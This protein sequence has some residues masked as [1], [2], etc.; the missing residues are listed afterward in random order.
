MIDLRKFVERR[1]LGDV[2]VSELDMSHVWCW[3]ADMTN[4]TWDKKWSQIQH[5][6]LVLN[7]E[8]AEDTITWKL[9][10]PDYVTEQTSQWHPRYVDHAENCQKTNWG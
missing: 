1:A 10:Y 8:C 6:Y 2:I 4:N 9:M 5:R 7:F 3:N